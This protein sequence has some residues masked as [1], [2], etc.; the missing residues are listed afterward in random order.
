MTCDLHDHYI[1]H[2]ES[3]TYQAKSDDLTIILC[4]C[5]YVVTIELPV[6]QYSSLVLD[7]AS[8]LLD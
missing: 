5:I 3:I 2:V 6:G 8:L 7:M 1:A 4:N